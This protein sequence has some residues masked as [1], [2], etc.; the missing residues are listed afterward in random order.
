MKKYIAFLFIA[1]LAIT[2]SL[3]FIICGILNSSSA[4]LANNFNNT[5]LLHGACDDEKYVYY[6]SENYRIMRISKETEIV[7]DMGVSTEFLSV[8]NIVDGYLYVNAA[9]YEGCTGYIKPCKINLDDI[10]DITY[11]DYESTHISSV[12]APLLL[13][14]D[15]TESLKSRKKQGKQTARINRLP[16]EKQGQN[17]KN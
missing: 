12:D 17:A 11:F 2:L 10:T 4:A 3:T 13:I 1:A 16:P 7:T 14:I 9:E 5:H 15:F 6:I 8:L